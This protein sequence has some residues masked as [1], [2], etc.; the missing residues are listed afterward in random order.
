VRL[1]LVGMILILL[2]MLV[3]VVGLPLAAYLGG[4]KFA[5]F[6]WIFPFPLIAFGNMTH[7]GPL[8]SIMSVLAFIVFVI[9]VVFFI[10]SIV[11]HHRGESEE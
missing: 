3:L 7:A 2:G 5:G 1:F 9:F 11:R 10:I 4:C 6:V 8:L